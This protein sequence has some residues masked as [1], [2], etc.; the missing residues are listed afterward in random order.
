MYCSSGRG[1]QPAEPTPSVRAAEGQHGVGAG[2]QV[3]G[4]FDR[5]HDLVGVRQG[6]D[7]QRAAVGRGQQAGHAFAGERR[8]ADVL[9]VAAFHR[10]GVRR[11]LLADA[12][13]VEPDVEAAFAVGVVL[14]RPA[15]QEGEL[16]EP[17]VQQQP[18]AEA[19]QRNAPALHHDTVVHG[20]RA[21]AIDRV[22]G[23][24][25]DAEAALAFGLDDRFDAHRGGTGGHGAEP[26]SYGLQVVR[27]KSVQLS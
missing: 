17:R 2:R 21:V 10:L 27:P 1:P 7:L 22:D 5:R 18:H 14:H 16:I 9:V 19:R 25:G 13:G 24:V 4:V 26:D 6:G 11:H 8:P 3:H 15:A 20:D 12:A 23:R